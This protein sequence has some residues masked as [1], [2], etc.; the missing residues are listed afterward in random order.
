MQRLV[1]KR[2]GLTTV[3]NHPGAIWAP[4]G[5]LRQ[6][7]LNKLESF[8]MQS[9]NT[10]NAEI[11]AECMTFGPKAEGVHV[12]VDADI[13]VYRAGFSA[14]KAEVEMTPLAIVTS[15]LETMVEGFWD[16]IHEE[17]GLPKTGSNL[18]CFLTGC[19]KIPNFRDDVAPYYKANRTEVKKPPYYQEL[20]DHIEYTY[21]TVVTEGVEADDYFG[22]ARKDSLEMAP[23]LLPVIVSI[24]K[25]LLMLEGLHY[26]FVK[27]QWKQTSLWDGHRFF[28]TQM[29]TGDN[30]DNIPGLKR[31][32]PK[33]AEKLL[34]DISDNDSMFMVTA[35]EYI[36]MHGMKRW[37]HEWNVHCDLL[38]ILRRLDEP[39]PWKV[40]NETFELYKHNLPEEAWQQN[41]DQEENDQANP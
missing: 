7:I 29:M 22:Q 32:G 38:W 35:K 36:K 33:K 14:S 25:D 20:R 39:C 6:I 3:G 11:A 13:L 12:L 34:G 15:R 16:K 2:K 37:Q 21:D 27:D 28:F 4:G 9:I 40:G 1:T 23:Q 26:N 30:A 18:T 17:L 8:K 31:Y 10:S 24:D 5:S 19:K 41:E